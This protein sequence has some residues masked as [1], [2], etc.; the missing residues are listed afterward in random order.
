MSWFLPDISRAAAQRLA[1]TRLGVVG[2][3]ERGKGPKRILSRLGTQSTTEGRGTCE[4]RTSAAGRALVKYERRVVRAHLNENA[5]FWV[6]NAG[7][8]TTTV[9]E[10][11]NRPAFLAQK[12]RSAHLDA[13]ALGAWY[14][15]YG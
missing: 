1:M 2:H 6:K 4:T 13:I 5:I 8:R 9:V 14:A 10:R 12:L 7:L 15:P 3:C 11:P